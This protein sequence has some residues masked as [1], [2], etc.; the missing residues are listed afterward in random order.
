[1]VKKASQVKALK[2]AHKSQTFDV[3]GIQYRASQHFRRE[4]ASKLPLRVDLVREPRNE[5]DPNAVSVEIHESGMKIGYLRRAV[6]EVMAPAFDNNSLVCV[7]AELIT[8][9]PETSEATAEIW[10]NHEGKLALDKFPPR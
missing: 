2:K 5:H 8:L 9:D 4:L 7:W 1:M 10:L 3:V 6:A